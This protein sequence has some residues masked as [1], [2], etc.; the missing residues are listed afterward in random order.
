MTL[1]ELAVRLGELDETKSHA[2]RELMALRDQQQR[3]EEL[4]SDRD[5]L[6]RYIAELPVALDNLR[7]MSWLAKIPA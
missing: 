3:V 7:C 1:E 2:G 6:L 4:E 5:T